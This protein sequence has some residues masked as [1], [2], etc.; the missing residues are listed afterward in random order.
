M[1]FWARPD[2]PSFA[3]EAIQTAYEVGT[4]EEMFTNKF[5]STCITRFHAPRAFSLP[6]RVIRYTILIAR[7]ICLRKQALMCLTNVTIWRVPMN[8]L[9]PTALSISFTFLCELINNL[10]PP[11]TFDL[12]AH[13]LFL[14]PLLSRGF[15]P[16]CFPRWET[17]SRKASCN[18]A[19]LV[20][21]RKALERIAVAV[22]E[23]KPKW[24]NSTL[25]R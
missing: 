9:D 8:G 2:A 15:L 6:F 24:M 25:I 16:V 20:S 1:H 14:F 18:L 11:R 23:T 13:F 10:Q 22:S 4:A 12:A 19:L 7:A 5:D 3:G 17:P 21:H